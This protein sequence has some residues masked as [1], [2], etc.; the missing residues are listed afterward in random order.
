M[1]IFGAKGNA[2]AEGRSVDTVIGPE[3]VFEGVLRTK[4]SVCVEGGF[5]GTLES[6]AAVIIGRSASVEAEVT[7]E[8]VS[9]NGRVRGNV[10]ALR[11]LDVGETGAIRGDVQAAAVTVAKGGLLEGSCRMSESAAQTPAG[12]ESA[13]PPAE[14]PRPVAPAVTLLQ[15]RGSRPA[16]AGTEDGAG[17]EA[18]GAGG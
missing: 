15:R 1:G 9:V 11:Q 14:E 12:N 18:A 17:K 4:N 10:R 7:A 5:R 2:K 16:P 8:Y 13:A 6:E 3:A